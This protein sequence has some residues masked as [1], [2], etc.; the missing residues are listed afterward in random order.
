MKDMQK[1]K[2]AIVIGASSGIGLEVAKQ[3]IDLG[4][5]VGIAAGLA[6]IC[7]GRAVLKNKNQKTEIAAEKTAV[8]NDYD[9]EDEFEDEDV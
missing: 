4:W 3:L 7:A 8:S 2:K 6:L 1:E 5:T 9:I